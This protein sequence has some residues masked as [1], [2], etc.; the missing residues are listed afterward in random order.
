MTEATAHASVSR[1]GTRVRIG[2]GI[3]DRGKCPEM[4]RGS[5]YAGAPG[6]P[7]R[8]GADDQSIGEERRE[9]RA[10]DLPAHG[11]HIVIDPTPHDAP[12]LHV[13]DRIGGAPVAI[14]R[15]PHAAHVDDVAPARVD[16]HVEGAAPEVGSPGAK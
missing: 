5:E 1:P 10:G 13:P 16:R 14:A 11:G 7:W 9:P 3:R 6:P 2:R 15:L 12:G 8:S 4:R